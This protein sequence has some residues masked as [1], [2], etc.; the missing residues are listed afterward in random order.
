MSEP[1]WDVV[2]IGS[3]FG[4]SITAA[5]LTEAGARV[6]LLERG[7]WWDTVPTRSMGIKSRA[8]FP[9]GLGMLRRAV[10]T[11][12]G[13]RV[14]TG[15]LTFNKRGMLEFFWSP[16]MEVI[17]SSGVG[18]GSHVYSAVHRR[19][20]A[21]D[22]WDGHV[23]EISEESMAPHNAAF[24]ARIQSTKPGE[25]NRP[26]GTSRERFHNHPGV[27]PVIPK[28]E[29]RTGFLLPEDPANPKKIVDENGVER[30]ESDYWSNDNGFLGSP[31]GAKSS[32]DIR[33]LA[34]ALKKGLEVR[35]LV[36][37]RTIRATGEGDARYAVVARDLRTGRTLRPRARTVIVAAGTMNTLRLL[38]TSVAAGD[39]PPIPGLGRRFSGNGDMR[40]FWDVNEPGSDLTLGLPSKGGIWLRGAEEPRV[41]IGLNNL[42]SL[43]HWPIPRKWR[44][45]LKRGSVA[46]AMGVDAADGV[47]RLEGGKLKI[48]F[49]PSNSPIYARVY[50]TMQQLAREAGGTMRMGKRPSSV[51]PM[52]GAC[53]GAP[54]AGGVVDAAGQVH[55]LPGL[56]VA[57]A[58]ALPAPTA[59]P[60]T[61]SIAAWA[62]NVAARLTA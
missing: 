56:H 53:L 51:H 28:V 59:A 25:N 3:G 18:G 41:A 44:E 4:G 17:C 7:P 35:D 32:L 21:P 48:D 60:P 38:L 14:P 24:L 42:P 34:P 33:Y 8:P 9:R 50:E 16:G 29:V 46:S 37:A 30:W 19:P 55:G 26:P 1:I 11:V 47:V 40:G 57:D 2:V 13:D 43:D 15:R 31:S 61:Q 45:R 10:R 54:E 20:A 49:D 27:E 52:G 58:A 23:E 62:E 22:Y 36:E 12:N 5:R 39:L 6:L